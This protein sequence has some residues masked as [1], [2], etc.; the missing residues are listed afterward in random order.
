MKNILKG[1][2]LVLGAIALIVITTWTVTVLQAKTKIDRQEQIKVIEVIKNIDIPCQNVDAL[3]LVKEILH[4]EMIN[5]TL[6]IYTKKDSIRDERERYRY[7]D[8]LYRADENAYD[9]W[10]ENQ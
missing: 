3:D 5:D 9:Q 4:W 6:H 8:S 1:V 7:I 2:N 10:M